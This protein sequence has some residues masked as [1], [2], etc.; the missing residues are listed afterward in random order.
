M[1][2]RFDFWSVS[3]AQK[4]KSADASV[5]HS[6]LDSRGSEEAGLLK[7]GSEKVWEGRTY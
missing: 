6:T 3:L 7:Y 2:A 5:S 1:V 4:P